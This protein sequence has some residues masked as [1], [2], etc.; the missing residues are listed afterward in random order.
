[1]HKSLRASTK[2]TGLEHA[3]PAQW[4]ARNHSLDERN[5]LKEMLA[6]LVLVNVTEHLS[7]DLGLKIL[8]TTE[9]WNKKRAK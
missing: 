4:Y 7:L 6:H 9:F 3:R 5:I 8:W 1:M 2:T